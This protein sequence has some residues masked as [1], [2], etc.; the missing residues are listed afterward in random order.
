MRHRKLN[1]EQPGRPKQLSYYI[2]DLMVEFI[3]THLRK[4]LPIDLYQ[5]AI[6]IIHRVICYQKKFRLDAAT[7]F[8]WK[9]LWH[10]LIALLKFI[11]NHETDLCKQAATFLLINQIVNI[12]NIFITFG[13]TFLHSDRDYDDLYYEI[14]RMHTTFENIYSLSKCIDHTG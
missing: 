13:D 9:E 8:S 4:S 3:L 6:G 11:L 5:L 2:L 10:C 7:E 14:I 1:E 12:F